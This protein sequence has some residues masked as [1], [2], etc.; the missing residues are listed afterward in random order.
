MTPRDGRGRRPVGVDEHDAP[1][2]PAPDHPARASTSA[3]VGQ[4]SGIGVP[5]RA[6][7]PAGRR[8]R[9]RT[10]RGRFLRVKA[11]AGRAR[12]VEPRIAV[13]RRLD[14]GRAP[15][16]VRLV[17]RGGIRAAGQRQRRDDHAGNAGGGTT[18]DGLTRTRYYGWPRPPDHPR[19][20]HQCDERTKTPRAPSPRSRKRVR[21]PRRRPVAAARRSPGERRTGPPLRSSPPATVA[22]SSGLATVAVLCTAGTQAT[23][24]GSGRRRGR[25]PG[26]LPAGCRRRLRPEL[27]HRDVVE[28]SWPCASVSSVS[29][30]SWCP[31]AIGGRPGGHGCLRGIWMR[32]DTAAL[33]S[34]WAPECH[35]AD[36]AGAASDDA[37]RPG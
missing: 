25:L 2:G 9:S 4:T 34:R 5:K 30:V 13:L 15:R 32:S 6:A 10:P 7:R 17:A 22:R 31:A 35:L 36:A 20:R 24:W 27:D 3:S 28:I 33:S 37:T 21:A 26:T 8:G 19:W 29:V 18:D 1:R 14:D 16:V 11:G 12:E 23:A